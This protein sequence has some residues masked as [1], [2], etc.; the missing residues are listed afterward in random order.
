MTSVTGQTHNPKTYKVTVVAGKKGDAVPVIKVENKPVMG[1]I[2][3]TK[4]GVES[5]DKM[6]N[7]NYTLVDNELRLTSLTDGKIYTAKT[8]KAGKLAF[9]NLPLGKNKLDE[10]KGS[11]EVVNTLKPIEVTL[12]WQDNLTEIV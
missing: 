5:G 8:D 10:T 9:K 11:A 2:T 3:V 7:E 12:T 6:W 1:E 4:K